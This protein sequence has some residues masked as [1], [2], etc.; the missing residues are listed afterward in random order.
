[1]YLFNFF[2]LIKYFLVILF[3]YINNS[4]CSINEKNQNAFISNIIYS[5]IKQKEFC[6]YNNTKSIFILLNDSSIFFSLENPFSLVNLTQKFFSLAKTEFQE[7]SETLTSD[8]NIGKPYKLFRS[9]VDSSLIFV[10]GSLGFNWVI[11]NCGNNIY[12][13]FTERTINDFVFHPTEKSWCLFS[14][15]SM[16]SDYI[17]QPC[18]IVNELYFSNNLVK[19][20]KLLKG[21]V[22]NFSW[23]IGNGTKAQ[24][25]IPKERILLTFE[26]RGRDNQTDLSAWNYKVDFAYSDDFFLTTNFGLRKG[27]KFIFN[28]NYLY[29]TKVIDQENNEIL[30]YTAAPDHKKYN[31]TPIDQNHSD[32]KVY[33]Y[34]FNSIED[35]FVYLFLNTYNIKSQFGSIYR[36]NYNGINFSLILKY[37]IRIGNGLSDFEKIKCLKGVYI[38]NVVNEDYINQLNSEISKLTNINANKA[39]SY[40]DNIKTVIT[41]NQGTTWHEIHAPKTDKNKND[42]KCGRFCFLHLYSYSSD[43]PPILSDEEAPGIIIA[44]GNI[45]DFLD[46]SYS[47]VGVFL[48]RDGGI[49]WAEIEKGPHVFAIGNHG[50]LLLM[51][52]YSTPTNEIQ[53]S[54]DDGEIWN[55]LNISNS[56]QSIE[57]KHIFKDNNQNKKYSNIFYISGKISHTN[58]NVLIHLNMDQFYFPPCKTDD[59]EIWSPS[60]SMDNRNKCL[61]GEEISFMRKKIGKGCISKEGFSH[62][63]SSKPCECTRLDFDCDEGYKRDELTNKCIIKEQEY[64]IN[65]IP[66][67]CEGYYKISKGY[68]KTPGNVC[69][70]GGE[71][72]SMYIECPHTFLDKML[73]YVFYFAIFLL[74]SILC[75]VVFKTYFED[76]FEKIKEFF[77]QKKAEFS[78]ISINTID[79]IHSLGLEGNDADDSEKKKLIGCN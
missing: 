18:K 36:S 56:G 58:Q 37:N 48:S 60:T 45:G 76:L 28:K 21:Y 15:F 3:L 57:I 70:K 46:Y 39:P 5:P 44:N 69:I 24:T 32:Y 71:F 13:I 12:S 9:P 49:N 59:F 67:I 6:S 77:F 30:L 2:L 8:S 64:L 54:I 22:T 16:C 34:Y 29:V 79:K 62:P 66:E 23:G 35:H 43:L 7:Y 42:I 17:H 20:Y 65:N 10:I 47:N 52:K 61:M 31:L 74:G 38:A 75:Y 41:L 1:M 55:T 14:A 11:E 51:A 27:N 50:M 26:N 78:S 40:F 63:L 68:V 73:K 25:D 19:Q 33:S 4:A 72:E 53:Y